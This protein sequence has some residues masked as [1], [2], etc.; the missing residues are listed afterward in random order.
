MKSELIALLKLDENADED[1]IVAA[2]KSYIDKTNEQ[3]AALKATS[4]TGGKVDLS[5]YVGLEVVE[6]LKTEIA[7]LRSDITTRE[8]D[9]LVDIAMSEGKLAPAQEQWARA[10]GET[11]I[12]ALKS[13]LDTAAVVVPPGKRQTDGKKLDDQGDIELTEEQVAICKNMGIAEADYKKQL[14]AQR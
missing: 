3:V 12:A 5:K 8:V 1:A 11:D 6:E 9:D 10:L 2:L 14:A 4:E 13:Y 7:T